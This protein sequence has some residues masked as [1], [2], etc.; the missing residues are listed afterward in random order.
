MYFASNT[1]L[2]S[3]AASGLPQTHLG[4]FNNLCL[5]PSLP[6]G[7][8]GCS[9]SGPYLPSGGYRLHSLQW[10]PKE[11]PIPAL[12]QPPTAQPLPAGLAHSGR[13]LPGL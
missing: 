10:G 1:L 4:P 5:W 11:Q 2:H 12:P 3:E 7:S 6:A 8:Y 9:R 13:H